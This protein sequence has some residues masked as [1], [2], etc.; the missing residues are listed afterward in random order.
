MTKV[1]ISRSGPRAITRT[2]PGGRVKVLRGEN[3]IEAARQAALATS[4]G[5]A[6]VALA[7]G[8]AGDAQAAR[9]VVADLVLPQNKVV[10]GTLA[11]AEA[12]FTTGTKFAWIYDGLI[13]VRE[14]TA[15]GS[16]F[17]LSQPTTA[18]LASSSMGRGSAMIAYTDDADIKTVL[19]QTVFAIAYGVKGD[20]TAQTAKLQEVINLAAGKLLVL[21][22]GEIVSGPL[23]Y[24]SFIRISGAGIGKT[25]LK[26]ENG[27]NTYFIRNENGALGNTGIVFEHFTIDGNQGNQ[28]SPATGLLLDKV[29]AS[30]LDIEVR[31][32][33]GMG[34]TV[35][36]GGYNYF[37]PLMNCHANG[38]R[39]AGYG[40]YIYSSD[41][42]VFNGGRYDDNCIGIAVEASGPGMHSN[43]N[44]IIGVK[45][46]G[47]RKE[48]DQSG[49]GIHFEQS[50]G[51][52]CNF[53]EV[54]GGMSVNNTGFGVT[55]T[56]V[57]V[58]IGGMTIKGNGQAGIA[59]LAA[60]GFQYNNNRL[61]GNGS[62]ALAGYRSEMIFD[63]PSYASDGLV[64]GNYMRGTY[65]LDGAIRTT[66][67][68]SAIKFINNDVD[69]YGLPYVISGQGDILVREEKGS[70]TATM[71]GGGGGITAT[72]D[73]RIS[74]DE[75]TLEFKA[76]LVGP[77]SGGT[78]AGF[79]GVPK[80][81]YPSYEQTVP[82]LVVDNGA[83]VLGAAKVAVNAIGTLHVGGSGAFNGA[84]NKGLP[85]GTKIR[86]RL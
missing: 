19:D 16:T 2:L 20:G 37:G 61:E 85:A 64:M 79:E 46:Q 63:A 35:S 84:G 52:N 70:F 60:T 69:G 39:T 14:R 28:F 53:C 58:K 5:A 26:L 32:C 75:V 30:R 68:G 24:P 45:A 25:I 83:V 73:W 66:Q 17:L 34:V 7:A 43:F 22:E 36:E 54:A 8:Y 9:D 27:T 72:V 62:T 42:N 47:N 15:G 23:T 67:P 1:I 40:V 18:A 50:D 74:S 33:H 51:G 81:L 21:P 76:G 48:F 71:T 57:S 59:T 13:E 80:N 29:T 82:A 4:N 49:A 38:L 10:G 86:Y 56:G 6:Q 44:K 77:S 78:L 41:G 55:N 12:L 11:A 65:A 31:N 3:T